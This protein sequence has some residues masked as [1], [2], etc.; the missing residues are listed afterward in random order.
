MIDWNL[1]LNTTT[2]DELLI[3]VDFLTQGMDKSLFHDSQNIPRF[4]VTGGMN[5]G[6]SMICEAGKQCIRQR[7]TVSLI[8]SL[9][10]VFV[11][12]G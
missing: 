6:K 5:Y 2:R 12:V 9:I 3:A 8:V 1:R 7:D 4:V 11:G 10:T